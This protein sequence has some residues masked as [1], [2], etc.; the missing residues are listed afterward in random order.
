M[1]ILAG[2]ILA[3]AGVA[4]LVGLLNQLP[5]LPDAAVDALA[6]LVGLAKGM[7]GFLPIGTIWTVFGLVLTIE[8]TFLIIR[9]LRWLWQRVRGQGGDDS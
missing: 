5:P 6:T 3:L 8:S 2:V 7:D 9:A 4:V 1:S